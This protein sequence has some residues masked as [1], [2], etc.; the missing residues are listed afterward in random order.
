MG[1]LSI[2]GL[3]LFALVGYSA[4]AVLAGRGK[5]VAPGI[6]DLLL[7]VALWVAAILCRP[8]LGKWLSLLVWLTLGGLTSAALTLG[9]RRRLPDAKKP[10]AVAAPTSLLKGLWEGWKRFAAELGNFQGR[11]VLAFFYFLVVTPFGVLVRMFA[12][13]MRTRKPAGGTAWIS[14]APLEDSIEKA[15]R[16]Y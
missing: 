15:R 10:A 2:L 9:R 8:A 6:L 16:Q 12:D 1:F 7:V 4:G 14:A 13:P 11:L 3:I 5:K